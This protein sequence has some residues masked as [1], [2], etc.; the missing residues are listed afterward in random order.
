MGE[1]TCLELS[2]VL[3]LVHLFWQAGSANQGYPLAYLLSSRDEPAEP[4]GLSAGRAKRAL[5][6]YMESFPVF[7]A[8]VIAFIATRHPAGIW[9]AVWVLAR[10]VY[11][12]LYLFNGVYFRTVAWAVSLVALVAMLIQLAL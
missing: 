1:L 2:V 12:P 10:I 7:A 5:A 9:P 6:N 4:K 11:L 3:W 8:L